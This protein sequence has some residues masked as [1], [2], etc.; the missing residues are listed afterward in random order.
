MIKMLGGEYW[1]RHKVSAPHIPAE[2]VRVEPHEG[3]PS[4]DFYIW[5]A[6]LDE[7]YPT[8]PAQLTRVKLSRA[9]SRPGEPKSSLPQEEAA[10]K[11]RRKPKVGPIIEVLEEMYPPHGDVPDTLT[12]T[13]LIGKI[14]RHR[15]KLEDT[16]SRD[17]VRRA[18][19]LTRKAALAVAAKK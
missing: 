4:Q 16:F 17:S 18:R 15:P 14:E 9:H 7:E 1:Q 3:I 8:N 10:P 11:P 5:R 19:E 6:E 2:G 13:Q 12:D